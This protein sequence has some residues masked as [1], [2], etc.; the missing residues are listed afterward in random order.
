L[1]SFPS[2]NAPKASIP[3]STPTG[4]IY[5]P[6]TY[7]KTDELIALAKI[8]AKH[9]GFYASHIRDESSL[10]F[11]AIEEILEVARRCGIR[12]HISHIKVEGRSVWGEAPDVIAILRRARKAGIEVTADQY[13]Y[14]A[15]STSLTATLIPAKYL[16]G[17]TKDMTARLEDKEIGPKMT[18]AIELA[19]KDYVGGKII[20]IARYAKNAKWQGKDL[21]AIAEAEKKSVLAIVIEITRNGDAQ[22]VGFGMSDEDVRLFMKEPYVATA[23]DGSSML[24]GNSVPHPR[25]YGTFPR[26]IGRFAIED[27]VI[28]L[29]QAIRSASG[30]PADILKLPERGYLKVGYYADIVVFDPKT[31]RDKATYEQPHQYSTGVKYLFV[32]GRLAI[33]QGKAT[34]VLAGKVLRHGN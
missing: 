25:S 16:E 27:N 20:K 14:T 13:P 21:L 34:N 31:F 5:N 24:P 10:V 29:S 8:A 12:V 9:K 6:G 22:I 4:L 30:L 28:S 1:A 19:I 23:S 3:S 11:Q 32:N 18:R 17:S 26:K 15:W 2:A 33:D 7:A